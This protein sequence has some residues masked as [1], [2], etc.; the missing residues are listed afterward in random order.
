MPPQGYRSCFVPHDI[1]AP[2]RGATS[3]PLAGLTAVVKDM[4][5]IAGE[6]AGCGSPEWLATHGPAA[7][8]SA[9]VQKILDAGVT[10]T[11]KTVC[12]EFFYSVSGTNA[13]YGTPINARAPGRLPGGSS[14]GSA[15]ACG[16]GLC[17]FALGSDTGGSVRVPASFNGIYGLRP[18]HGR[19]EHSGVTD[20]APTFDVPGWFATTPGVFRKV[21]AVLLDSR[22]VAAKIERVVVLEDAFAQAEERVADLL[23]TLLEFMGDDLPAMAHGKIA[24]DGFDSWREAFRIVQAYEVWRTFGE[25]V[26]THRPKIGPGVRERI[27]FAATVTKMQADAASSV[28]L[29]ARRHIR[30]VAVPGSI[31]ALPT[32]PSISPRVEIAGAELEDF[33]VRVM[34]LTCMAGVSGL[35]QVS[36]PAGTIDGCPVGLSFIGWDGGDE[37]LLD[38]AC[39]LSRHCGMA[40]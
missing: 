23:R 22:R 32:A 1:K 18:T 35:P 40:A 6:R 39:D 25:F 36:I 34:R 30:Q 12:D 20:M 14:S 16:A 27:D 2:I 21:G 11:G 31:L 8:H 10:I 38:L 4:Y 26:T 13:H 29:D 9:P 37:A 15:A 24:P 5:D 17:D 33:R 3:G 28:V 19:I 7:R